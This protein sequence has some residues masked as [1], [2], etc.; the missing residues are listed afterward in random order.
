[1]LLLSTTSISIRWYRTDLATGVFHLCLT[2]LHSL[3][4]FVNFNSSFYNIQHFLWQAAQLNSLLDALYEKKIKETAHSKTTTVPLKSLVLVL[5]HEMQNFNFINNS[6]LSKCLPLIHTVDDDS[7]TETANFRADLNQKILNNSKTTSSIFRTFIADLDIEA[8][9]VGCRKYRQLIQEGLLN[10]HNKT[11][12]EL[13]PHSRLISSA[14]LV[15]AAFEMWFNNVDLGADE[16]E[17][18]VEV[19]RNFLLKSSLAPTIEAM[20]MDVTARN[21]LVGPSLLSSAKENVVEKLCDV[22]RKM[23][24]RDFFQNIAF[25]ESDD[26]A[27]AQC[28]FSKTEELK[29]VKQHLLKLDHVVSDCHFL[30]SNSEELWFVRNAKGCSFGKNSRKTAVK[31]SKNSIPDAVMKEIKEKVA[32]IVSSYDPEG[33]ETM[34]SVIN[35]YF[36]AKYLKTADDKPSVKR[37]SDMTEESHT[38]DE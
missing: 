12:R 35:K 23:E 4:R 27:F 16:T 34:K 36:N 18:M 21:K 14:S 3:S 1:M 7:T 5:Q 25:L 38:T 20:S 2:P 32:G 31:L 26:I 28:L 10:S 37:I 33:T 8:L 19:A 17:F 30:S 13:S 22:V 24:P 15:L 9:N 11:P 29:I 6:A